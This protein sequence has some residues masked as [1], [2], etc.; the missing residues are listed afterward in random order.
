MN[1]K[2]HSLYNQVGTDDPEK[3]LDEI[4]NIVKPKKF[5]KKNSK[6]NFN[7]KIPT[8]KDHFKIFR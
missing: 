3:E 4:I 8:P 1:L 6:R 2:K 7:V 5:S